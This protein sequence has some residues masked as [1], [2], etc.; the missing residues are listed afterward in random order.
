MNVGQ[1]I[2][3]DLHE[4]APQALPDDEGTQM[5]DMQ[6]LGDVGSAKGLEIL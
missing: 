2:V 1:Y 5:A 3:T 4:D 6:C